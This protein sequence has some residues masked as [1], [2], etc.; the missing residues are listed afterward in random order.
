MCFFKVGSSDCWGVKNRLQVMNDIFVIIIFCNNINDV[1]VVVIVG[2][3]Q[4]WIFFD[5]YLIKNKVFKNNEL[6]K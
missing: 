5:G 6:L 1:C 3:M 2:R 4:I